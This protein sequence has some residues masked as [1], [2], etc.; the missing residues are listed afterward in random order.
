MTKRLTIQ[1]AVDEFDCYDL[2]KEIIESYGEDLEDPSLISDL[3]DLIDEYDEEFDFWPDLEGDFSE[4]FERN[5]KDAIT[6]L[7]EEND[8]LSFVD[9]D[10]SGEGDIPDI[11]DKDFDDTDA[12]M[13]IGLDDE[14]DL[15][16]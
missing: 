15:E 8:D 13:D 3:Y 4:S 12:D 1:M 10:Y 16:Y 9:A 14:E 2:Y 5:L 7:V 6:T 11:F